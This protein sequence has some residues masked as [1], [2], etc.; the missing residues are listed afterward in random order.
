[1]LWQGTVIRPTGKVTSG[2]YRMPALQVGPRPNR[3]VPDILK[4]LAPT[5]TRRDRRLT[6]QR[7]SWYDCYTE[8]TWFLEPEGVSLSRGRHQ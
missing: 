4:S 7:F 2:A 6:G 3:C 1:M 5:I 8:D